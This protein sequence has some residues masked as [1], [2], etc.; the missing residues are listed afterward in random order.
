MSRILVY[1]RS[2]LPRLVGFALAYAL[3]AK[4]VATVFTADGDVVIVWF[5]VGLALVALLMWGMK[6]WPGVF[7]G[8]L[9]AGLMMDDPPGTSVFFAL[10][11]TLES[12]FGAWLLRRIRG[13]VT[14]RKQAEESLR[15]AALVYENSSEAMVVTDAD[16]TILAVNPAFT[17]TTGYAEAE[18]IGRNPRILSSGRHDAAFYQAMW[19]AIDTDGHWQGEIWNR[20]KD[21]EIYV[22]ELTINTIFDDAGTPRRRVALF[23]DITQRKAAEEQLSRQANFDPL[24]G[25]PNRHMLYDRLEQEI[26]KSHRTHLPLGLMLLD[27]DH[28]KEVNDTLGHSM[29]DALLQEVA[30]RLSGCVRETDTVARLGGDEFAVILGEMDNPGNIERIAQDILQKLASPYALGNEVAYVSSSIGITLYP[31]DASDLEHL[32]KNAD[33]AM[34]AAKHAGRNRFSYFTLSMQEAAQTR[35]RLT[36]DLRTALAEQQFRLHYQPIVELES[37]AVHKAEALI[38]WNHPARGLVSP[39]EFIPLAEDTGLIVD[40]GDWVFRTAVQQ[41]GQWRATHHP[42]F[43][44]GINKSPVQFKTPNGAC[45]AWGAHL[46]TVGLPGESLVVEITE[47]LLMDAT[48]TTSDNLLDLRDAGIQVAIDDFGTGYS[49]LAY[50]KKFHIDYL[51]IDQ[52]FTRNLAPDSNDLALCEAI[53]VMAHK[54]GLKAIAEGVET[55]DQRDLLVAIGCDYAQ[56]YLFAKP[57]P[58]ENF[59]AWMKGQKA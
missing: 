14:S 25:L 30:Q 54:L 7:L 48:V 46:Q 39:A 18:A 44:V 6:F 47:G 34:Y 50:L 8:G 49:S 1:G 32:L 43:Q 45:P 41:V 3:L 23:S 29:G 27:L 59:D 40:I 26:K 55:E 4:F 28:F 53:I 35:L 21:G 9:A 11:T 36:N 10:G 12:L 5:P 52:S 37:G 17:R 19:A 16:G 15:L 56:G 22:E 42:A 58:P 57:M 20:R 31:A 24:T 2:D 51:K 33:Q 13:F 38:R